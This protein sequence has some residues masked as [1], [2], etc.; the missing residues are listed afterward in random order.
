M[1]YDSKSQGGVI[2][3][4]RQNK[5]KNFEGKPIKNHEQIGKLDKLR[6]KVA[7]LTYAK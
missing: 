2:N 3:N 7:T 1:D 6:K 4:W 5:W